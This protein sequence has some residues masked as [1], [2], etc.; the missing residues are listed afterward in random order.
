M[1]VIPEKEISLS[2]LK[3]FSFLDWCGSIFTKRR[4]LTLDMTN[5][6]LGKQA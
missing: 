4:T 5:G 1:A 2:Q 6:T 3:V